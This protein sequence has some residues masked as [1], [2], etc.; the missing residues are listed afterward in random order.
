MMPTKLI[1][2]EM[3]MSTKDIKQEGGGGHPLH[4]KDHSVPSGQS[5]GP[6]SSMFQRHSMGVP[7]SHSQ[8]QQA[9]MAAAAREEDLRRFVISFISLFNTLH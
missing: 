9:H 5:M 1:K 6:Y 3:G 4:P 2:S 8:Q 7:P